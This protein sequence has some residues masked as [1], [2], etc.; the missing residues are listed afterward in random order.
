MKPS[1]RRKAFFACLTLLALGVLFEGVSYLTATILE[2][3]PFSFER[4]AARRSQVIGD[5]ERGEVVHVG[6]DP[7]REIGAD[8]ITTG[9]EVLHPYLGFVFNPELNERE[10]R[11]ERGELLITPQGFFQAPQALPKSEGDVRIGIFGGSVAMLFA[12]E[13]GAKLT[14]LLAAAPLYAG[15]RL[16]I[17]C[18]ALGGYKQPQQLLTLTYLLTLGKRFDVVINIDGF[19]E[20][21]LGT[22]DNYRHGV[23]PFYPRAWK[24]RVDLIPDR[25]RQVQI[26][27]LA[28]VRNHRARQA[29]RVSGI[30]KY[31]VTVNLL[32]SLL[33]RRLANRL[34]REQIVLAEM[35]TAH[36][37]YQWQGPFAPQPT[38]EALSAEL[39]RHWRD[40]SRQMHHLSRANGARYLHVL[41]PNQYLPDS[42]PMDRAER[43][44]A[45]DPNSPYRGPA[46]AGYPRLIAAGAELRREGVAFL[47]ASGLFANVEEPLYVDSCCHFNHRGNELLAQTIATAILEMAP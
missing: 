37:T 25:E 27:R 1:R 42:K 46:A 14:E 2:G 33:D 31:S 26:G 22:F 24:Q 45:F 18:L 21:A 19:N 41:Q 5:Q 30:L 32:W 6:P 13:G 34:V 43:L 20:L 47:D 16:T 40:S 7:A 17:E 9:R 23:Y 35:P 11:Q 12:F 44:V 15:R 10:Q 39:A 3:R 38:D 4:F 36:H 29:R 28:M 8:H